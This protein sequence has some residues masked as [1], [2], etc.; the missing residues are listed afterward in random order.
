MFGATQLGEPGVRGCDQVTHFVNCI[1]LWICIINFLKAR[2][3][4][5]SLSSLVMNLFIQVAIVLELAL[6][7]SHLG[8]FWAKTHDFTHIFGYKV[9]RSKTQPSLSTTLTEHEHLSHS[10]RSYEWRS[11]LDLSF[12]FLRLIVSARRRHGVG[13]CRLVIRRVTEISPYGFLSPSQIQSIRVACRKAST[14]IGIWDMISLACDSANSKLHLSTRIPTYLIT[15][16]IDAT[17]A[18]QS[19]N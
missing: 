1:T 9:D 18:N 4:L 2:V 19:H 14:E 3:S 17:G 11:G 16:R 13:N 12:P 15:K 8:D 7:P 6:D 10:F 5:R